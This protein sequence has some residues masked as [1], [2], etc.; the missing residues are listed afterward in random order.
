MGLEIALQRFEVGRRTLAW[1]EAELHQLACGVVDED[2]QRAGL[3]ALL[4][5][6]VLAAVDLH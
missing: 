3:A 2:Q 4:E 5:P 6:A 1:Y